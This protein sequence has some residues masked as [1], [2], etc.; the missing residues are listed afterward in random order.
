M[1]GQIKLSPKNE[2][3]ISFENNPD[4]SDKGPNPAYKSID[5]PDP[6]LQPSKPNSDKASLKDFD[7]LL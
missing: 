2:T 3:N 4:A 6:Q 1:V 5:L 7:H